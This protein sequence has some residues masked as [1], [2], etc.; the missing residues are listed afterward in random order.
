MLICN[1]KGGFGNHL[2]TYF[3]ACILMDKY[4]IRDIYLELDDVNKN[5][6]QSID[7][8]ESI[9]KIIKNVNDK[10]NEKSCELIEINDIETY[11]N[12]LNN[13]IKFDKSKNY[14][15]NIIHVR[16]MDFYL[17]NINI[18]NKYLNFNYYETNEK[19]IVLSLRLGMGKNEVVKPSPFEGEL[20]LPFDYYKKAIKFFKNINKNINKLIICSD[21]FEDEYINNFYN[22]FNDI[23][24]ELYKKNTLEQFECIINSKFY[25]SS[26]SSFSLLGA[27]LNKNNST[28]PY[29]KESGSPFPFEFNKPYA[30]ILNVNKPNCHKI[31]I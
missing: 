27:L 13:N 8:Q 17:N 30:K 5:S 15:I 16:D 21:N 2:M 11:F 31:I 18:I 12:I 24:I 7:T 23:E 10:S 4:E 25:I 6:F 22:E 14:K 19:M 9:F 29:F 28:I 1:L 26:N 3:L 20:R